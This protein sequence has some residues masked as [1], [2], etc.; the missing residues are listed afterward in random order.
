MTPSRVEVSVDGDTHRVEVPAEW[1]GALTLTVNY[2]RGRPSK[3]ILVGR[4][5][6][7]MLKEHEAEERGQ[8]G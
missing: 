1:S 4:A 6:A 2:H 3:K 8:D 7:V 5:Q